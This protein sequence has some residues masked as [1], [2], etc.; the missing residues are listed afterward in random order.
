MECTWKG[1]GWLLFWLSTL[2]FKEFI[3][4]PSDPAGGKGRRSNVG[5]GNALPLGES[6]WFWLE[7]GWTWSESGLMR[8]LKGLLPPV[9]SRPSG[10]NDP[11]C[12]LLKVDGMNWF[13]PFWKRDPS[14]GT[15]P[16]N[17]A[18]RSFW[19][20][21]LRRGRICP[22]SSPK[23][24][25]PLRKLGCWLK[26]SF[27]E[28]PLNWPLD[29]DPNCEPNNGLP[30]DANRV[31][32][33][34]VPNG[35]RLLPNEEPK[36]CELESANCPPDRSSWL[37][38]GNDPCREFCRPSW[39]LDWPKPSWLEFCPK[40]SWLD[41]WPKPSWLEVWPNPSW[42]LRN[43]PRELDRPNGEL[44]SEKADDW[45][46]NELVWNGD[47]PDDCR[48]NRF[49][50]PNWLGWPNPNGLCEPNWFCRP[51]GFWKPN[52]FCRPNWLCRPNWFCRP[53]WFWRPSWFCRPNWFWRPSWPCRPNWFW[54]PNWPGKP[55][56]FAPL[57]WPWSPSELSWFVCKPAIP[58]ENRLLNGEAPN[59]DNGRNGDDVCANGLLKP[60]EEPK[61]PGWFSDGDE[62]F[63]PADKGLRS[64]SSALL[65][66]EESRATTRKTVK[67]VTRTLGEC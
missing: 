34:A 37:D 52:W 2:P 23:D 54:R 3:P 51:N 28:M 60:N 19:N 24:D 49:C 38:D 4:L 13:N 35:S 8:L 66:D 62:A 32:C 14:D 65:T 1:R 47:C 45:G 31:F 46:E 5:L 36:F 11:N 26:G 30:K 43:P 9:S 18:D 42:G 59:W 41:V 56:W 57:S 10:L 27:S 7:N 63:L 12:W 58:E 21:P 44:K 40:P 61:D 25:D 15:F 55:N 6:C 17:G 64:S 48:P 67:I 20:R 22:L 16:L 29:S 33:E 39:L 53:S 50:W